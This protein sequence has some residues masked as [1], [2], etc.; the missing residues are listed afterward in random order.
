MNLIEEDE[1]ENDSIIED[2][3]LSKLLTKWK[4]GIN[5]IKDIDI[6]EKKSLIFYIE[7][8]EGKITEKI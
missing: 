5:N 8:I 6:S 2:D 1:D 3:G 4:K 7:I